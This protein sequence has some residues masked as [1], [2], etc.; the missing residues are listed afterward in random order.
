MQSLYDRADIYDLFENDR[1]WGIVREHWKKV[2]G[3]KKIRSFL[4]V[5]YGTGNLTLPLA[6]LGIEIY[7]SDL[8]DAMLRRGKEKAEQKGFQVNLRQ[9]DFRNLGRAFNQKFACVASTGN[10][11]AYVTNGEVLDVLEQMDS[12]VNPGGWLYF[13]LRNWDKILREK[14]RFYVYEPVFV[15]DARVNCVQL[16]DYNSDGSMTF[17][18]LYTFERDNRFFKKE[19]FAERYIPIKREILLKKL[20]DLGYRDLQAH[21]HPAC[22]EGISAEDA[23]WYCVIA[24]KARD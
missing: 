24:R 14:N 20:A 15:D 7:G 5:S 17:N 10:S 13:D 9:C 12:L 2:L 16:W 23:E 8:S 6:E 18:I 1:R 11:L 3:E 22:F 21:C 19:Q 4:D